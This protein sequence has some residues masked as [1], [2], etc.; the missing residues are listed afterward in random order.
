MYCVYILYSKKLDRF[1]T[2]STS[3][4]DKRMEFHDSPEARKF[5]AKAHD[6]VL[7][8]TITCESK[9]QALSIE[10]HIKSMKSKIYIRNLKQYVE[11]KEKLKS[12]FE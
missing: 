11:I 2:G 3:D 9:S 7:F 10:K 1:Y 12:K 6:W 5:T 8:D 4:F